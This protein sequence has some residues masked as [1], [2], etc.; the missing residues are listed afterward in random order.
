MLNG[1]RPIR[2]VRWPHHDSQE[3]WVADA[4]DDLSEATL[5]I[6]SPVAGFIG[7]GS[8]QAR[9]QAHDHTSKQSHT[10]PSWYDFPQYYDLGFRD[11]TAREVRF[12]R[13]PSQNFALNP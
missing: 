6:V 13:R 12:L 7:D 2:T 5:Y 8:D 3:Y 11:D 1:I 9:F 10:K 4:R